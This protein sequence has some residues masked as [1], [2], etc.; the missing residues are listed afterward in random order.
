MG[1]PDDTDVSSKSNVSVSGANTSDITKGITEHCTSNGTSASI[2][3]ST[4]VRTTMSKS[5]QVFNQSHS[6][7]SIVQLDGPNDPHDNKKD[8]KLSKQQNKASK[9]SNSNKHQF[10]FKKSN[11]ES[12]TE[13]KPASTS[14]NSNKVINSKKSNINSSTKSTPVIRSAHSNKASDSKHLP[15]KIIQFFPKV[16]NLPPI[17]PLPKDVQVVGWKKPKKC[18]SK[19]K[20]TLPPPEIPI[21]PPPKSQ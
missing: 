18:K 21:K 8:S 2:I 4:P 10:K 15:N 3:T 9:I 1:C 19:T 5:S 13:S 6:S 20:D 7:D 12:Y 11:S 14:A 17:V 16:S